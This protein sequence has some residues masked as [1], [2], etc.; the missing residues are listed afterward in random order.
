MA[1]YTPPVAPAEPIVAIIPALGKRTGFLGMGVDNYSLL[2]APARMVFAHFTNRMMQ[3]A[4]ATARAEAKGQGRGF[5]GQWAAQLA[6][7]DVLCRQ[8]QQLPVDTILAQYPGSFFIP[9][10]QVRRVRVEQPYADDDEPTPKPELT[11]EATAGKF[12]FTLSGMSMG[13]ARRALQQTL[14]YVVK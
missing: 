5:F 13:D 3:E 4:V 8:Y 1:A 12:T 7:L 2:L 14:G 6:W 10:A 9:N 11:V